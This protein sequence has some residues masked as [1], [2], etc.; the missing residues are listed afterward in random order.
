MPTRRRAAAAALCAA[1]GAMPLRLGPAGL[2]AAASGALAQ[3]SGSRPERVR[4]LSTTDRSAAQGLIDDFERRHPQL[5]VDYVELGSVQLEAKARDEAGPAGA[6]VLWSSAMDL[7]I[8]LVNDGFAARHASRHAPSLPRWAVWKHEAYGTTHE[9]VGMLVRRE[10][11]ATLPRTHAALAAL[12]LAQRERFAGRT[13]TYDIAR[14]GL[15]YL[16]AAQDLMANPRHWELLGALAQTRA[17]LHAD[18]QSMLERVRAGDALI[19]YNVLG[20]YAEAFARRHPEVA[21][22]YFD[23][24]TLVASRVAFVARHAPHPHAARLWLDHLLSPEGQQALAGGGA[25]IPL[26]SA[27]GREGSVLQPAA[28]GPASGP[29]LRPITLGPGLLAF[30]DQSKRE[31]LLRRWR[32]TFGVPG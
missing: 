1:G 31:S 24:Y 23:D 32:S 30:L 28:S 20:P 25:L 26:R 8:R 29:T 16:L 14:A 11:A 7:Q 2:L 19:A 22:L 13:A 27:A 15:G 17:S 21:V 6:D 5:G 18:T 12:L 4:V 3:G 10:L 9:P